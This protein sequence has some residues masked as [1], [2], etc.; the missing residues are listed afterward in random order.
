MT[1]SFAARKPAAEPLVSMGASAP[2]R[3]RRVVRGRPEGQSAAALLD[4]RDGSRQDRLRASK[5][6]RA[7]LQD[8]GQRPRRRP[9]RLSAAVPPRAAA[10]QRA[11][12]LPRPAASS[13][14]PR[15]SR[16]SPFGRKLGAA[17]GAGKG[18]KGGRPPARGG[19]PGEGLQE[20]STAGANR[21]ARAKAIARAAAAS[22]PGQYPGRCPGKA[23][24]ALH[25]HRHGCTGICPGTLPH[26][27]IPISTVW[28]RAW[29]SSKA[30]CARCRFCWRC[31]QR[32]RSAP[33][34]GRAPSAL[35]LFTMPRCRR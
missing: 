14:P 9:G 29:V 16:W 33:G 28:V 6:S 20:H 22:M 27:S 3:R 2:G 30:R 26:R 12:R 5:P 10:R 18:G 1:R 4:R 24:P 32:A 25:G 8:H 13:L 31:S 11:G 17:A 23:A 7:R 35:S 19:P 34:S 21:I 15:C